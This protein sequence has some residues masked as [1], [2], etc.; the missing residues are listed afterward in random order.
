MPSHAGQ[1]VSDQG[2]TCP[3]DHVRV[4]DW[5]LCVILAPFKQPYYTPVAGR[6]ILAGNQAQRRKVNS[7]EHLRQGVEQ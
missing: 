5:S 2:R 3:I 4:S 1:N 7:A 6:S